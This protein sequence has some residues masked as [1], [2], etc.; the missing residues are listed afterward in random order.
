MASTARTVVRRRLGARSGGGSGPC[1]Q[2]PAFVL[3][4]GRYKSFEAS[5]PAVQLFPGGINDR[6]VIVGEYLA[7]DRESGF[8]RDRRGRITRIDLPGAAGTQVDNINDRGQIVGDDSTVSAFLPGEGSRGYVLERGKV[9]R[10]DVPEA[11]LTV[12]HG[13]NDRGQVVGEYNDA[14]GMDRGFLWTR[15]RVTTFAVADATFT[16]PN[17]FNDRGEIVGIYGDTAGAIHGFHLRHGRTTTLDAPG[18]TAT[19]PYDV[20]DR[21]QIV[22]SAFTPTADDPFAAA[23]GF[24]LRDGIEGPFTEVRFPGAPRT[25]ATGIDDRGRIV[26]VYENPNYQSSTATPRPQLGLLSISGR[27]RGGCSG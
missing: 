6:G 20:N 25:V 7:P 5:D 17:A 3:D 24:V 11:R 16:K 23:R 4:R 13:I 2:F 19:I 18:A 12:P 10:I 8:V 27:Q 1:S 14:N 15:G 9:T 26:G 22:V 21:G